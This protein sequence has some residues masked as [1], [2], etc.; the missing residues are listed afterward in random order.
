MVKEEKKKAMPYFFFFA[1]RGTFA[2]LKKVSSGTINN[3]GLF[4]KV[5]ERCGINAR[6]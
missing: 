6:V 5:S 3:T 1:R 2:I 4:L